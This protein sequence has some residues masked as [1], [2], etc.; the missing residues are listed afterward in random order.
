MDIKSEKRW[1]TVPVTDIDIMFVGSLH[2]VVSV[3]PDDRYEDTPEHITVWFASPK[4]KQVVER[5]VYLKRNM[6]SYR[7]RDRL[8]RVEDTSPLPVIEGEADVPTG[9]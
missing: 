8:L 9:D 3:Q 6:A 4:T 7:Y 5:V 1:K 2:D